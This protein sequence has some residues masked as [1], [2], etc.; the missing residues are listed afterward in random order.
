MY[1]N[2]SSQNGKALSFYAIDSPPPSLFP[3]TFSNSS[4]NLSSCSSSSSSSPVSNSVALRLKYN[5]GFPFVSSMSNKAKGN[6]SNSSY[7]T[8]A[9]DANDLSMMPMTKNL[10]RQ[11][12]NGYF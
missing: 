2:H 8:C 12:I 11:D 1:V 4:L 7:N 6:V 5:R 10:T 9:N 3:Q